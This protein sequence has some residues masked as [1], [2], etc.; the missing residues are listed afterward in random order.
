MSDSTSDILSRK[1]DYSRFGLV[2]AGLQK[3]LGPSGLAL[4]LVRE[5]LLGL[6]LSQTPKLLDYQL[7]HAQRS[8][9]NTTS[10]FSIYVTLKMLRWV[11][12]QGGVAVMEQRNREK[13]KLLYDVLD[14][15]KLYKAVSDPENRSI[16]NV[17]FRL[18]DDEMENRFL[19]QSLNE[20]LYA[21]KG[22]RDVGGIR[23]SI[24][25]SMPLKGVKTLA[26]FMQD[27]ER[28]ET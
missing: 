13:S 28:R 21:L 8:L 11:E 2:Y 22:H 26:D 27:F 1:E 12:K 17:T 4:V 20:G 6:A 10:V 9:A 25:N 15:S 14:H 23:A 24:Y 7:A 3:N 5:D 16:C 19:E 18:D